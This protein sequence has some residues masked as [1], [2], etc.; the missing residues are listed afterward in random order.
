MYRNCVYDNKSRK[1]HL[2]SWSENGERIREEHDFKPYIL[3]EDKK[4]TEKS[5]YGTA[6]KK[7][8]F[9]SGYERNNFVKDSNIKRIYENLPPYQ[10]F[11]I[12]NYWSVCEDDNFSQHPLKVAYFDIECPG[13]SFPEPELAESVINLITIFNS[14]SKM[15]HVFGLKNFHTTRDDV[16]YYWCK[17][18]EELLKSFIKLFQKEGFDVLSGWNISAF[19]VPYL[20]NRITFQLGKEWVDKLSPTGR[21][22]EKTNPNGKFGMPSNE[23]VIEGL[24]ILDY[25]VIYQKFNLEK[26]ESYKLDN[27]GE[28]ELGDNSPYAAFF[29][30][31]YPPFYLTLKGFY[32]QAI[33]YQLNLKTFHASFNTFSGNYQIQLEFVGYKFNILNEISM[34]HLLATP[35]MYSTRFDISK[36]PTSAEGG[37][38][39]IESTTKQSNT[40]AG[41]ASNSQND[42][43]TQIV[44][45]KGY[46]KVIEVYS[47]Y[48]AKGLLDPD[49]PEMTFAQFMNSL[50]NFEK[51]IIDSYTKVDVEPLTNIRAYKEILKNYYNEIYASDTSWYNTYM[52]LRPIV[53]N[54][55][56]YVYTFK[57]TILKDPTRQQAARTL[58]SGFTSQF[59]ER[60]AEN[61]TLGVKGAAPIKN[62]ITYDTMLINVNVND[63]DLT[64]T[65]IQRTGILSPTTADTK[66]T[67]TY[68]KNLY[69]TGVEVNTNTLNVIKPPFFIF[70][71]NT[72]TSQVEPRFENLIYQLEAEANRKLTDYETRLTA[73]FSRKIE[74]SKIGLGFRPTVRNICAVIMASAEAFIRL[75]DEVHTNAWNVKYDPVRQLSI[76]DNPSSAPGTDTL[77]NIKKSQE[78]AN[79]NQGLSTSQRKKTIW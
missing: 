22:Y 8:E 1:I 26:Q 64:K 45:E 34:G 7:K 4:G 79:Q 30:L 75:M 77:G 63:I 69:N 24:S 14:E 59:N 41:Q 46:Q 23:Y 72:V 70:K 16:K 20:V 54:N 53:L 15:Y 11:L 6:L 2:F 28:V 47:E 74:D 39:N 67:D 18:E 61:P 40:I 19:D 12:D 9:V 5:I 66:S 21:I 48:K 55:G 68:L 78:S 62:S 13:I 65:T 33:K 32:G 50:E 60:L 51:T 73:D 17:S 76:L 29:N 43:V 71:S 49:F 57:E 56:T 10:Q 35:H 38:K 52:D 37:N 27:I 25:Y 36:S 44:S 31:P 58:L 3:L 42:V